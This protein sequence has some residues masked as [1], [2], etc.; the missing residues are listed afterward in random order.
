MRGPRHG[1][2]FV[3]AAPGS[4][5]SQRAASRGGRRPGAHRHR[6]Q[7]PTSRGVDAPAPPAPLS[8]GRP[9]GRVSP[10]ALQPQ[11]CWPG[12][13]AGR[14]GRAGRSPLRSGG[15][16]LRAPGKP[17]AGERRCPLLGL[18]ATRGRRQKRV[19]RGGGGESP[20]PVA[21]PHPSGRRSPLSSGETREQ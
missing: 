18:G 11:R 1:S 8:P 17:G 6:R 7:S 10:C 9:R 14:W 12:G 21:P 19:R 13:A 15:G 16:P 4:P 3:A 5:E 20:D 2:P